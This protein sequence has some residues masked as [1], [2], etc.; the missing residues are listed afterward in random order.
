MDVIR[1]KARYIL[2]TGNGAKSTS[3]FPY[4]ATP[5]PF[6]GFCGRFSDPSFPLLQGACASRQKGEW[7]HCNRLHKGLLTARSWKEEMKKYD[8]RIM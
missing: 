1:S 8:D 7:L 2:T 6:C 5:I 3:K 4:Q